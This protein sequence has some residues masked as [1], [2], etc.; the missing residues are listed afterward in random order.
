MPCLERF[1]RQDADYKAEV[2]P[3][4]VTLRLAIEAGVSNLWYKYVGFAGKV[5]GTDSFGFSA[6]GGTVMD[7]FGI[8]TKNLVETAK[9]MLSE[10]QRRLPSKDFPDAGLQATTVGS[11][12]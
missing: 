5:I 9:T 12:P 11:L 3:P 6:P 1:D 4:S 7:A 2:L 10:A 8:N